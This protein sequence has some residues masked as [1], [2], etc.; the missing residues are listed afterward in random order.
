MMSERLFYIYSNN[1][2]SSIPG[3]MW[4]TLLPFANDKLL[5][6]G[7]TPDSKGDRSTGSLRHHHV[8]LISTFMGCFTSTV[9]RAPRKYILKLKACITGEKSKVR[10]PTLLLLF[11]ADNGGHTEQHG[12]CTPGLHGWADA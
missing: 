8:F 12:H 1:D 4:R 7:R 5:T 3:T 10:M 11:F 6:L 2:F 9:C